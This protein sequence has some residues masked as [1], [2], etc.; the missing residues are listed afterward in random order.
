MNESE[1]LWGYKNNDAFL[2][3][4]YRCEKCGQL[5]IIWNSRDGVTPFTAKCQKCDG[6]ISHILW[7]CDKRTPEY[8]PKIGSRIFINLTEGRYNQKKKEYI[9]NNWE[10]G[11]MAMCKAF[12]TKEEA[13]RILA[14]DFKEGMPEL[15]VYEG[16]TL[17]EKQCISFD[18]WYSTQHA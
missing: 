3:M 13:F 7:E 8:K 14:N 1:K 4:N 6:W 10:N 11:P 2:L 16:Q 12:K 17:E 15:I 5:E 9:D 18:E